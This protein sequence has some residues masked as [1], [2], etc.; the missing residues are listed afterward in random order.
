MCTGA[1]QRGMAQIFA[2]AASQ[3][4]T[5]SPTLTAAETRSGAR[6]A[7]RRPEAAPAARR[8]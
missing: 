7:A 2:A 6:G 1:M 3:A 8:S 4:R 5:T